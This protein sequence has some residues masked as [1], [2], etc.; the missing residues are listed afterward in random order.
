MLIK[1]L[2]IKIFLLS[3]AV[4]EMS[5][6]SSQEMVF[7]T[8][9]QPKSRIME[10]G[11]I[12][13]IVMKDKSSV[14][15]FLDDMEIKCLA[16]NEGFQKTD[17]Y[18]IYNSQS[19]YQTYNT[20][21]GHSLIQNEY[22][23]FLANNKKNQFFV[24][25][26]NLGQKTHSSQLLNLKLKKERYLE[27]ISHEG[28]FYL[29]TVKKS[30]SV[31]KIYEFIGSKLRT[32][33]EFDFSRL[34]ISNGSYPDLY[35]TLLRSTLNRQ[36]LS[37][38]KI[39]TKIPIPLEIASQKFKLYFFGNKIYLAFD[40]SLQNTKIINIDLNSYEYAFNVI[41]HKQLDNCKGLNTVSNSFL[42][43][44][45]LF[46]VKSCRLGLHLR[47]NNINNSDIISEYSVNSNEEIQFKNGA[48]IQEG[49]T[50]IYTQGRDKELDKTK[51]ILR[52]ISNSKI[53]IS[54]YETNNKLILMIGGYKEVQQAT[55]GGMTFM[56]G[57]SI[58]TPYGNVAAPAAYSYNP[59]M[60]GYGGYKNTRAV[61][62]KSILDKSNLKHIKNESPVRTA[63]DKIKDFEKTKDINNE[64]LFRVGDSYIFGYYNKFK[65][66]YALHKFLDDN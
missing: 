24:Q 62:F 17:E 33:K 31:L 16:L 60:F 64:T 61:Y 54:A 34:P 56:P 49:G 25:S 12:L 65:K 19:T 20:L 22:S 50:V 45:I 5:R 13:P 10:K 2:Y 4:I 30:S 39:A 26:I 9:A 27:S 21:L 11:N 58:A 55:G 29:L 35:S 1:T 3:T 59:M 53:G 37:I 41:M 43:D 23:L 36:K 63:F 57:V 66:T 42:L 51:Q 18:N 40:N 6:L 15:F 52:K 47:A 14:L 32:Q 44:S 8:K 28:K 46:T 38:T 48:I 7:E